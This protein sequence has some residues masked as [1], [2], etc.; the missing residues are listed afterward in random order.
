ME[1][2]INTNVKS[3]VANPKYLTPAM[4]MLNKLR[5]LNTTKNTKGLK[6]CRIQSFRV[7][8]TFN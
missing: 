3:V 4:D 8:L 6:V 5:L 1:N 7:C 2:K